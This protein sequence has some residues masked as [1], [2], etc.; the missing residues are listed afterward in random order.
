MKWPFSFSTMLFR[1]FLFLP[2]Y[3]SRM[4]QQ[5]GKRPKGV[6]S[7]ACVYREHSFLNGE[8]PPWWSQ[9]RQYAKFPPKSRMFWCFYPLL[10]LCWST[11]RIWELAARAPNSRRHQQDLYSTLSWRWSSRANPV[12]LSCWALQD[13]PEAWPSGRRAR[14]SHSPSEKRWCLFLWALW[15]HGLQGQKWAGRPEDSWST[16]GSEAEALSNLKSKCVM[17]QSFTL[18]Y[19]LLSLSR[20][21]LWLD[22]G[23]QA[24]PTSTHCQILPDNQMTRK[25]CMC[26]NI[27]P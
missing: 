8:S 16:W 3:E 13:R 10:W 27:A 17:S 24:Q 22:S 12:A 9:K 2:L 25:V 23:T 1:P 7:C 26:V 20:F 5:I 21:G 14:S 6:K 18:C 15:V 4:T 19:I 11:G